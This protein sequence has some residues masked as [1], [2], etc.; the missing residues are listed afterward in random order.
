MKRFLVFSGDYYYPAGGMDDFDID[1]ETRDQCIQYIKSKILH[2]K[3]QHEKY[4]WAHVFDC[5]TKKI[6]NIDLKELE[7]I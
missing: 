2:K 1:L 6:E 5:Q 3:R 7:T 4:K